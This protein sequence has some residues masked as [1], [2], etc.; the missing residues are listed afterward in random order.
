G[1]AE[2]LP[3]KRAWKGPGAGQYPG[4]PLGKNPGD[5]WTFPNVKANHI[6]KTSHPCQ[7]PIELVERFVLSTTDPG[8]LV[9]DPYLGVGT[10]AC[11]ALLHGRRTARAE[12]VSEYLAIA[13]ERVRR[14]AAAT[15][16]PRP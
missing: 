10:T 16:G 2:K 12:I 4:P 5:V 15:I 11:A 14:L 8:D 1:G 13:R 9:L 7:F 6:E 3:G